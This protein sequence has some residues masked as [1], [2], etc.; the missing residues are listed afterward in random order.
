MRNNP[1]LLLPLRFGL[2]AKR[3]PFGDGLH[4]AKAANQT[5]HEKPIIQFG[6]PSKA[7]L[8]YI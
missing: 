3:H 5:Q 7:L 6:L 4:Y 8:E 2:A 1:T